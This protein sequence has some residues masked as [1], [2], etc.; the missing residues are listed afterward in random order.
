MGMR[1]FRVQKG[2]TGVQHV[3]GLGSL[4]PPVDGIVVQSRMCLAVGKWMRLS[5]LGYGRTATTLFMQ[6]CCAA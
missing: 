3:L 2:A 1:C 4:Q 6:V 5:Q